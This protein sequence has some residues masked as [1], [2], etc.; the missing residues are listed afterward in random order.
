MAD[1][2]TLNQGL[3]QLAADWPKEEK[4]AGR[5]KI[6]AESYKGTSLYAVSLPTPDHG[7]DSL[8]GK[9]LEIVVGVA[10]DKLLL[11]AGR[12]A[13]PRFKEAFDRVQSGRGK[14]V[15][16]L[17]IRL[18]V[19]AVASLVGT[20]STNKQIKAGA[21]MLAGFG[22]TAGSKNHVSFTVTPIARGVRGRLEVEAGLLK[23]LGSLGQ[24]SGWLNADGLY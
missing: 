24:L 14:E 17:E 8:L 13:G 10:G 6:R 3:R 16:P 18:A 12:D 9:T 15:P 11:A 2:A 20:L 1:G 5:F 21:A 22:I 23:M 19:P 4:A 7:L